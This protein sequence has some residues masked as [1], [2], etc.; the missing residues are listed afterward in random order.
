MAMELF[1]GSAMKFGDKI[2]LFYNDAEWV[3][4]TVLM[5][6]TL[7]RRQKLTIWLINPARLLRSLRDH[8]FLLSASLLRYRWWSHLSEKKVIHLYKAVDKL[9]QRSRDLDFANDRTAYMMECP[10]LVFL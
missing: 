3:R 5:D 1:S 6:V 9:L 10:H 4:H 7:Q 2:I 8:A